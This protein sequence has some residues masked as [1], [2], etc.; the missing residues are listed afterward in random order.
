MTLTCA[1]PTRQASTGS[2]ARNDDRAAMVA[3]QAAMAGCGP[4]QS[5]PA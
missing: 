5:S 4:R 1:A 3:C 2:V